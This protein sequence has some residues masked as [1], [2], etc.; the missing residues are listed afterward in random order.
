[1]FGQE[2]QLQELKE[3]ASQ[4]ALQLATSDLRVRQLLAASEDA[5]RLTDRIS[6]LGEERRLIL[7]QK[8]ESDFNVSALG[9][10]LEAKTAA[11]DKLEADLRA[12]MERFEYSTRNAVNVSEAVVQKMLTFQQENERLVREKQQL[13]AEK[14]RVSHLLACT[15]IKCK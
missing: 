1:M 10:T 7:A 9:S 11:F 4:L 3:K 6:A 14:D 12:R 15:E 8:A 2:G 13:L 5:S